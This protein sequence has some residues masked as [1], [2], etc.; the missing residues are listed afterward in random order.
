MFL[1]NK[2]FSLWQTQYRQ[3]KA[4]SDGNNLLNQTYLRIEDLDS[5]TLASSSDYSLVAKKGILHQLANE[6]KIGWIEHYLIKLT[7][8]MGECE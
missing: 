2:I 4:E 1:K 3:F 8:Y 7:K 5:T 6:K